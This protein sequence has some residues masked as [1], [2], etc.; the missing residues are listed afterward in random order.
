MNKIYTASVTARGA[1]TVDFWVKLTTSN[2]YRNGY[3]EKVWQ[4]S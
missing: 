1:A 4:K 2:N 3:K